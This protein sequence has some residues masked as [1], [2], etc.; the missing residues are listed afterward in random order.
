M[1]AIATHEH[2]IVFII[3]LLD[4]T[5]GGYSGGFAD[6]TWACFRYSV[7]LCD[8]DD[9]DDNDDDYSN[10]SDDNLMMTMVM[11]MIVMI[12]IVILVMII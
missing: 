12:I 8:D 11:M 4:R 6:G 2:S 5:Y 9:D 10:F 3:G 7:G 1:H